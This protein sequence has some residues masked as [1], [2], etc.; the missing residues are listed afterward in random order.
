VKDRLD[1]LAD[2]AVR[3]ALSLELGWAIEHH[4]KL[5][6]TQDRARS[7]ADAGEERVLVVADEQTAGRGR[8]GRVWV[9]P[10]G[11]ALLASWVFRPLVP[12]AAVFV[13]LAG[14]AVARALASLGVPGAKLKWPNDVQ[15]AAKKVGGV[16]ADAITVEDGGA[17]VLGIG[18]NVHQTR[19]E[20]GEVAA[21]AT[22]LAAEGHLVDRLALL[23]RI[24][25]ELER[26]ASSTD[27]R[28]LA[29]GEWRERSST[30]GREVEVS[31]PD[32]AAPLRGIARALADDGALVVDTASGPHHVIA[33]DVKVV[34]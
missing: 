27:E 24:C 26:I 22:S 14:V 21:I 13:L 11:K 33:G 30:L 29:L 7:L 15:L 9:A 5:P 12:D 6:T 1:L 32:G 18:V 17:I 20:L 28:Q 4:A 2:P 23:A 31:S 34:S 25:P 10:R 3:S 8:H 16:L 19:G